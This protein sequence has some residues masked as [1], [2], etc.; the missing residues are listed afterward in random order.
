MADSFVAADAYER[1]EPATLSWRGLLARLGFFG[2]GEKAQ[3]LEDVVDAQPPGD[4]D[5]QLLEYVVVKQ[6]VL[7]L[8][9]NL[10]CLYV[11]FVRSSDRAYRFLGFVRRCHRYGRWDLAVFDPLKNVI[12]I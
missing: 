1:G 9:E 12:K 11:R 5:V 10:A 8:A 2:Y 7:P 4:G 3:L 6:T